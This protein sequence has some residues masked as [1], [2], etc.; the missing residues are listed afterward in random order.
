LP[1]IAGVVI[2]VEYVG[3]KAIEEILPE[4]DVPVAAA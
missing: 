1:L 4:T 3:L 2:A